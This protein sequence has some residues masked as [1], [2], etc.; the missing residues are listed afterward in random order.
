MGVNKLPVRFVYLSL[1]VVEL[2][3]VAL[4][5]GPRRRVQVVRLHPRHGVGQ[6]ARLQP[7]HV[8]ARK[9]GN[10]QTEMR[11]R[12]ASRYDVRQIVGVF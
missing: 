9:V 3:L 6:S 5:L 10:G 7:R 2:D 1:N 12:G 11:R 8:P 4:L